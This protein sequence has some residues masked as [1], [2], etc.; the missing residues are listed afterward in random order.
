MDKETEE[1]EATKKNQAGILFKEQEEKR[2]KEIDEFTDELI[3][4]E[5]SIGCE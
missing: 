4:R 5:E 1:L 3:S 2:Q